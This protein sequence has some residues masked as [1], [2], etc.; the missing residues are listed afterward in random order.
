MKKPLSWSGL[1]RG[2]RS[3][4]LSNQHRKLNRGKGYAPAAQGEGKETRSTSLNRTATLVGEKRVTNVKPSTQGAGGG[5]QRGYPLSIPVRE[6]ATR[7]TFSEICLSGESAE[8]QICRVPLRISGD[9][10]NGRERNIGS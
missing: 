5:R 9:T 7:E 6:M 2:K 1:E 4:H 8:L 3:S 10:T